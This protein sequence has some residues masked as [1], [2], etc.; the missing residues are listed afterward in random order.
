MILVKVSSQNLNSDS[1]LE[2]R[3]ALGRN[4][5]TGM[6]DPHQQ[7][8]V[9]LFQRDVDPGNGI[10]TGNLMPD[11]QANRKTASHSP[12]LCPKMGF[13]VTT[14]GEFLES[15]IG[16]VSLGRFRAMNPWSGV[17]KGCFAF[18]CPASHSYR[19]PPPC[20]VATTF[21]KF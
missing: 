12:V 17:A 21:T 3:G 11:W 14:R 13:V 4:P 15:R 8:P 2:K 1:L 6:N 9:P 18:A 19:G 10:Y 7:M 20:H 16:F 5:N